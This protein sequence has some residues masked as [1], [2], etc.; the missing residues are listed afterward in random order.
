MTPD[1]FVAALRAEG[2]WVIERP[3]WRTHNRNHK[4]PFGP[5]NGVMIHHT[6]SSGEL[7]SVELCED[8][9]PELPGPLCHN[10]IPKS[11]TV[12]MIANGRANH[13]GTGDPNVF[14]AVKDERYGDKPPATHVHEGQSGVDGNTHFYGAECV[15]LGD[16]KDRWPVGQL[17]GMVRY[18]A[19][20]CR[21]HGWSAKSVIAH[22]EWSD[23][24]PDP[25]GPGMVSMT[26]FRELVQLRLDHAA[27]WNPGDAHVPDDPSVPTPTTPIPGGSMTAPARTILSMTLATPVTLLDGIPQTI[28]WDAEHADDGNQHGAGGKTVVSNSRYSA[29]VNLTLEGLAAGETV[30]IWQAEENASGGVVWSGPAVAVQG[31]GDGT[32]PVKAAVPFIETTFNKLVFVVKSNSLAPVD[33]TAARVSVQSWLN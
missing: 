22:R 27:S 17:D 29:V 12:Y 10:V 33:M 15:N 21:F 19:A 32:K 9:Y 6:A 28:Y 23:W 20:I 5:V 7:S 24:K 2:C 16:G 31:L 13:A 18:A 25:A 8:G 3:G 4:G 11:G 30:E 1:Q 26:G 14:A